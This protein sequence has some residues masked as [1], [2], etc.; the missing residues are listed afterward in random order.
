[1]RTVIDVIMVRT[2][3][4]TKNLFAAIVGNPPYV[5]IR[6]LAKSHTTAEVAE[7]RERFT[8][9][10]GNFDLYV[11]FIERALQWLQPGGR[12]GF[13][14]PNKWAT[15]DYAERQNPGVSFVAEL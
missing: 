10:R 2:A 5:S 4:P 3:D 6:E 12:L 9:A 14:I 7:L 8:T 13:I 1:M 11:L 15:L